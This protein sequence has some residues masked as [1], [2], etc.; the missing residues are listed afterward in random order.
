MY[1]KYMVNI[2]MKSKTFS[3]KNKQLTFHMQYTYAGVFAY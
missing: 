1:Y 3:D 2:Y